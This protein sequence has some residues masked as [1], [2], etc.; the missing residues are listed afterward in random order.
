[1][2][3]L[4]RRGRRGTRRSER[5]AKNESLQPS[6]P[7][8]TTTPTALPTFP[9]PPQPPPP[10]PWPPELAADVAVRLLGMVERQLELLDQL[11]RAADGD[12]RTLERLYAVDHQI[13]RI[14]RQAHGLQVLAGVQSVFPG[15][16]AASLLDVVRIALGMIDHFE[17][18]ELGDIAS[19]TVIDHAVED[20]ALLLAELLDNAVRYGGRA[21]V[22][23][24]TTEAGLTALYAW[25]EGTGCDPRWLTELNAWLAGPVQPVTE[26]V[27]RQHGLTVVHH[28]ARR[29]NIHVT[30]AQ[31]PGGPGHRPGTVA[32]I[33][34]G[35]H[36]FTSA[37]S[38]PVDLSKTVQRY[39]SPLTDVSGP[40][41]GRYRMDG[42][43]PPLP[44]RT[45]GASL[46]DETPS[47]PAQQTGT[48]P[49][50]SLLDLAT[51]FEPPQEP[52]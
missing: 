18:V 51:A 1:M 17:R 11:Q 20:L 16:T 25:D 22:G 9:S 46:A 29:H 39:T 2:G 8:T 4:S 43:S 50:G 49:G 6:A 5:S 34:L 30:L 32:T 23:T 19:L 3:W 35:P 28:L 40:V 27:A 45:P 12:H 41:V 15:G 47:A 13:M 44:V 24:F 33:H 7:A 31:T 10:P 37:P 21:R 38:T 48:A 42:G 36:L 14:R 52:S 26:R